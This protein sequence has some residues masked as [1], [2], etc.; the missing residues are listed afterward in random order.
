MK[1]TKDKKYSIYEELD[2]TQYSDH[3]A[4][5]KG[6]DVGDDFGFWDWDDWDP[7]YQEM[8]NAMSDE[9]LTCECG[10]IHCDVENHY[11]FCPMYE[12]W[13]KKMGIID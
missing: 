3:L 9:K 8:V 12:S 11:D 6:K 2:Y 7:F 5:K 4:T 13:A 10:G 1:L